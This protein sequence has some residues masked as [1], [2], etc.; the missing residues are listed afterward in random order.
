[1]ALLWKMIC[2]L[3][4]PMSLRHPVVISSIHLSS[5]YMR[6]VDVYSRNF[7]KISYGVATISR[8]L[9]TIGLFCRISSL[10][11]GSFAKKTYNF[12]ASTH[13]S[14]PIA[15]FLKSQL[16]K[17]SEDS[18]LQNFSKVSSTVVCYDSLCL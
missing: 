11:Q 1:M 9:K 4:D 13:R 5:P 17:N 18:A 16:A 7:S 8:L 6:G 10:L 2:N 12:E 3:G 15:K 14:H